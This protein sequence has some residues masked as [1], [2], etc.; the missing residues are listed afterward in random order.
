MRQHKNIDIF[1]QQ[2]Q[3]R[4]KQKT[5]NS[6]QRLFATA[7]GEKTDCYAVTPY[8]GNF[9][10]R[11]AGFDMSEC[12]RDAKKMTQAQIKA[13]E[14]IGQDVV[15]AQSDQYYI[16]EGLGVKT[17]F[18]PNS[19][20]SVIEIGLKDISDVNK[21]KITD[22]Y[23]DGR[24]YVYIEAVG[25]LHQHFKDE[26]PIRAPGA[27]AFTLAGH[28]LGVDNF[29]TE[30]AIAELEEDLD[31][32][33]N[34]FELI[35]IAY[36]SHYKYVEACVKAGA[37]IVQS[38]DSLASLDIISPAIYEKYAFPYEKRFFERI[39]KLKSEYDFL[40]LLHICGD[41]TSILHLLADTGCDILEVDYKVDM[42][43]Y[44][45]KMGNSM[46]LMGNINPSGSILVGTEEE[47][48]QEARK[49]IETAGING[50]YYLGSGCEIAVNAPVENVK[51]LVKFGHSNSP[52]FL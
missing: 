15:V 4:I 18:Q 25:L 32:I 46:C 45:K 5:M 50:R 31:K 23:K 42:A 10:I 36:E 14:M 33:N 40:T 19:L 28:V 21:L 17:Q 2:N 22:P 8:N 13:W 30:L 38:A 39:N 26:V 6:K 27:G 41:N 12:Q 1:E 44:K 24:M 43:Y 20:P 52:T 3:R 29:I 34:I 9:A 7:K 35:E 47:V 11:A 37:S 16:S 48:V 49:A 51:A